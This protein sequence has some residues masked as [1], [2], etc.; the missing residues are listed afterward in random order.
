MHALYD[1]QHPVSSCAFSLSASTA[2]LRLRP[3]RQ[4]TSL[5][6]LL[7]VRRGS[8]T[9]QVS[10]PSASALPKP[11]SPPSHL[12]AS[13]KRQAPKA[14]SKSS[15]PLRKLGLA[16]ALGAAAA[17]AS[18][19]GPV[20]VTRVIAV[21]GSISSLPLGLAMLAVGVVNFASITL[22]FPANMG[23]MITAG[24]VLGAPA[25]F[26]ALYVSKL[27]AA[28]VAFS[29][30]RGILAGWAQDRLD[31]VPKLKRSLA[32][33]GKKRGWSLVLTMRLSPFP[34]FLLNYCASLMSAVTLKDYALGT[35]LGIVPGILNLVLI[36]GA[37]RD[38]SAG[39]VAGTSLL[40]IGIKVALVSSSLA[41][42]YF[43]TRAVR[44]ALDEQQD[45][46]V[47]MDKGSEMRDITDS[48]R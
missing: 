37:A 10:P 22:C 17:I 23:L 3:Q 28:L 36:G 11:P 15:S 32:A 7:L 8:I 40:G 12:H 45:A 39:A 44:S 20:L 2:S 46:G 27:A 18:V 6:P 33:A 24:A 47:T 35:A 19:Y 43:V 30:A 4:V 48:A 34:G 16:A 25:A 31:A 21:Y 14:K 13:G 29:L 38:V 41:M 42:T 1:D 5:R 9:P 26:A